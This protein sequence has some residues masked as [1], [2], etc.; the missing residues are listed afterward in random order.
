[1][2]IRTKED[3]LGA[4]AEILELPTRS[5]QIVQ[6]TVQ[7]ALCTVMDARTLLLDIQ[8]AIIEGGLDAFRKRREQALA[9]L[10]DT[11]IRRRAPGVDVKTDPLLAEIG[12]ALDLLKMVDV[13]SEVFPAVA[14]R[15]PKWEIA[16]FIHEQQGF[17]REA[18]ESGLRRR[19]K[20]EHAPLEARLLARIEEKKPWWPEWADSLREACRHHIDRASREGGQVHPAADDPEILFHI[21]VMSESRAQET[22]GR[23]AGGASDL[24]AHL[25]AIRTRIDLVMSAQQESAA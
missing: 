8:A 16:R 4:L 10:R 9:R 2:Y 11:Q 13:L 17:V 1:M 15:H 21:I 5:G 14:A 25:A 23:L 3:A 7:V 20:P 22:L 12:S 19:G 6:A 24:A 18:L